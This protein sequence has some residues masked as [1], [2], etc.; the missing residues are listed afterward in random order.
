[1]SMLVRGAKSL[2]NTIAQKG[3]YIDKKR[4]SFYEAGL[5]NKK[6]YSLQYVVVFNYNRELIYYTMNTLIHFC[7]H[8]KRHDK[9]TF[10]NV[11]AMLIINQLPCY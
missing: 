3:R 9:L 1:M 2:N 8:L 10:D 5:I 11:N 4:K 6:T 7:R